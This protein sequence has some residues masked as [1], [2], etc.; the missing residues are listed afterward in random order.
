MTAHTSNE[1][2]VGTSR[3]RSPHTLLQS[4]TPYTGTPITSLLGHVLHYRP[5]NLTYNGR[6]T[7]VSWTLAERDGNIVVANY[8]PPAYLTANWSAMND[9]AGRT[10][11]MIGTSL[12]P[13]QPTNPTGK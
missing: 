7:P 4:G 6:H 11:L 2:E 12:R 1:Q 10:L 5:S 13:R 9:A 3:P 8:F